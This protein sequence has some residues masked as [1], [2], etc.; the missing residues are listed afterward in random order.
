[1]FPDDKYHAW[2]FKKLVEHPFGVKLI[3][4]ITYST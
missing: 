1:M 4:R 2:V 3:H